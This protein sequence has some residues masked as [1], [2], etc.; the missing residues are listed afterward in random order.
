MTCYL[1]QMHWLFDALDLDDDKP[2]RQRVDVAIRAELEMPESAKCPEV[3]AAIKALPDA[4]RE[5]LIPEVGARL[6]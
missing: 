3:W 1:R 2:N 5:A 6:R 4:Q